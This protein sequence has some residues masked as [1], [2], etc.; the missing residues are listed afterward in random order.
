ME[1]YFWYG[2]NSFEK[3]NTSKLSN[4]G[5]IGAYGHFWKQPCGVPS[6]DTLHFVPSH[7]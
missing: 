3:K 5:L 6:I 2:Q 4:H 1:D 7:I